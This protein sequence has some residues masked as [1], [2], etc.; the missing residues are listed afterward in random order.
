MAQDLNISVR[1][2]NENKSH[3]YFLYIQGGYVHLVGESSTNKNMTKLV[4]LVTPRTYS[5]RIII[6]I[7]SPIEYLIYL[8]DN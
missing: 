1:G 3:I 5:S 7:S 6:V 8:I 2:D 4:C